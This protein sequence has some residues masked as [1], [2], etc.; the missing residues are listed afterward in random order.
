MLRDALN[1]AGFN[2][3]ADTLYSVGD[4]ADRGSESVKVIRYLMSLEDHYKG[5]LGN[6]DLWLLDYLKD[7][8]SEPLWVHHNGGIATLDSFRSNNVA[9]E[10]KKKMYEWL[11]SCPFIRKVD[12]FMIMHGGTGF[13]RQEDLDMIAEGNAPMAACQEVAWD[14]TYIHA[15]LMDDA[16]SC[17]RIPPL[18]TD[19]TMIVGHTPLLEPFFSEKYKLIAIDTGAGH[20]KKITVLDLDDMQYWQSGAV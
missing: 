2:P 1:A 5:V 8:K 4:I 6:H 13:Y 12:G 9:A 3:D 11:R 16:G 20:G 14:R 17:P 15:A 10:E 19:L 7:G 18:E